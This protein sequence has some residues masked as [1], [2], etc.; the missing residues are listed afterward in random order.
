M[1]EIYP[2]LSQVSGEHRLHLAHDSQP[3]VQ[4]PLCIHVHRKS[5]RGAADND[6]APAQRSSTQ[7]QSGGSAPLKSSMTAIKSTA[8]SSATKISSSST[9]ITN[10]S[11]LSSG[12]SGR[13][14]V[15]GEGLSISRVGETAEF[16]VDA[17]ACP[18]GHL[19]AML[20]SE[21]GEFPVEVSSITL[22]C[23]F[24]QIP[25]RSSP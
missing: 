23:S 6:L 2:L 11:S 3:L 20:V 19:K 13:V 15:R 14:V 7:S 16:V 25:L 8:D 22:M 21:K 18:E 1:S 17:S 24:L 4:S 9:A 12:S 10:K 5:S